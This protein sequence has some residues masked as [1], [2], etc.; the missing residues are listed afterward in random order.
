MLGYLYLQ[1]GVE[2]L[3]VDIVLKPLHHSPYLWEKREEG[4]NY[5]LS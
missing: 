3:L 1:W 4:L 5:V 2:Q